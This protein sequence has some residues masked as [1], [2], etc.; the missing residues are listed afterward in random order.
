M[1]GEA[2][3]R[4]SLSL[5]FQRKQNLEWQKLREHLHLQLQQDIERSE[6]IPDF[7]NELFIFYMETQKD[8]NM[9]LQDL[10]CVLKVECED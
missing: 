7:C 6:N 2:V 4:T 1:A 8:I 3:S 9:L 5:A 10:L